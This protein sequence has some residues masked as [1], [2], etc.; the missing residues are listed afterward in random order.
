MAL[1]RL[2]VVRLAVVIAWLVVRIIRCRLGPGRTRYSIC[3]HVGVDPWQVKAT[4]PSLDGR[5]CRGSCC[6]CCRCCHRRCCCYPSN[7]S[8]GFVRW[9]RVTVHAWHGELAARIRFVLGVFVRRLLVVRWG[10]A[11]LRAVCL[12]ENNKAALRVVFGDGIKERHLIDGAA[13]L[14]LLIGGYARGIRQGGVVFPRQSRSLVLDE[15]PRRIASPSVMAKVA[16]PVVV[17]S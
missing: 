8:S 15:C 6:C 17:G 3:I 16:G 12:L 4:L 13:V 14:G 2:V 5:L 7:G 10:T 11:A 9:C 1:L